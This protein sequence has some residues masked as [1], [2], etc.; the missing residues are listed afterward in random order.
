MMGRT[1]CLES[2]SRGAEGPEARGSGADA[3]LGELI[4]RVERT[5]ARVIGGNGEPPVPRAVRIGEEVITGPYAVVARAQVQ[6]VIADERLGGCG[7]SRP[8][9]ARV[10][11]RGAP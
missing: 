7:G 8:L 10:R 5:E 9:G 4:E 6:A 3:L 2:S 1:R 11:G